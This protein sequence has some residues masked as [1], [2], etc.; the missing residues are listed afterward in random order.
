MRLYFDECCS[1]RLKV[2]LIELFAADYPDVE[3]SHV[4]DYYNQGTSDST[5]LTPLQEDKD[6][7][8][9]TADLGR[10]G[11]EKLPLVC[12]DLGITH[13]ALSNSLRKSGY[14]KQKDA[15]VT[16]WDQLIKQVPLLAKGTQVKLRI[17]VYR[18]GVER[19]ELRVGG[20][21]LSS[22]LDG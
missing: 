20:K 2:E 7:V 11:K 18:N 5:W 17:K 4:L 9:L 6:I 15:I 12:K 1:R 14:S 10:T 21:S 13:V 19:F 16:V 8:V 22:I 3:I